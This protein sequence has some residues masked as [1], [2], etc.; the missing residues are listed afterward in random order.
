MALAQLL[1]YAILRSEGARVPALR[2]S[3]DEPCFAQ[4]GNLV[5]V[6]Q[7]TPLVPPNHCFIDEGAVARKILHNCERIA[8]F[9]FVEYQAMPVG[10]SRYIHNHVTLWVSPNY[11]ATSREA[12]LLLLFL[13]NFLIFGE[14]V[15]R[16][17]LNG[18]LTYL[19]GLDWRRAECSSLEN[20]FLAMFRVQGEQVPP[21]TLRF[22]VLDIIT[23]VTRW[24]DKL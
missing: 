6:F 12:R 16:F 5:S 20:K 7:L 14:A 15:A 9:V 1:Q 2:V 17:R 19:Q 18:W 8:I 11:I 21:S 22:F 3:E 13:I 10:D 23:K 24:I 4:Y